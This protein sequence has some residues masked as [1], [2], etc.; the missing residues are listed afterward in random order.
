VIHILKVEY[1]RSV[2]DKA[3]CDHPELFP[4]D[5]SLKYEMK[6]IRISRKLK[7]YVRRISV[8]DITIQSIHLL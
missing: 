3:I 1:F 7:I 2:L 6:D 8:M 5:I 4:P